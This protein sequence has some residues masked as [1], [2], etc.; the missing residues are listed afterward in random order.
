[1]RPY[2][3]TLASV[4]QE[5]RGKVAPKC[6]L[7]TLP[8]CCSPLNLQLNSVFNC[9]TQT[10]AVLFIAFPRSEQGML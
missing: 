9:N 10:Q 5:G 1:M 7:D 4:V 3:S 6:E 2:W 8:A